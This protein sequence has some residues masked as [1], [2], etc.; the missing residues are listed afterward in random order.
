MTSTELEKLTETEFS[1]AGLWKV[2][3]QNESQ[4]LEFPDGLFA[5]LVVDD[6]S[7]LV[8]ID[9]AAQEIRER[10]RQ[11]SIELDV[12]V[13][14][15]WKIE[16]V[17][18]VGTSYT[19][20]TPRLAES[21][22]ATL[23]SGK[24][25]TKVEVDV[26]HPVWRG[27]TTQVPGSLPECSFGEIGK[28]SAEETNLVRHVVMEFLDFQLSLGGANYWDPVRN[29]KLELNESALQYLLDHNTVGQR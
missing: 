28:P 7:T 21:F 10:L 14:A 3:N 11:R 16:E 29:R 18:H 4:F 19:A 17:L 26:T 22:L 27:I 15:H 12:I 25:K 23:A 1:G 20:G 24:S 5:E 2:I 8:D 9:R 6:A 13:R